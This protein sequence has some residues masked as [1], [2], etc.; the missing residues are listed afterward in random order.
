MEERCAES[1]PFLEKGDGSVG[2]KKRKGKRVGQRVKD[3]LL[4]AY[5]PLAVV[6]T[7]LAVGYYSSASSSCSP[8]A[9]SAAVMDLNLFPCT[10]MIYTTFCPSVVTKNTNGS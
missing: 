5:I 2:L 9:P 3:V 7:M 6:Y 4:L 10:S 1:E 8:G